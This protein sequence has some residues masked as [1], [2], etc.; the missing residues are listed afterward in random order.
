MA[1]ISC[2]LVSFSPFFVKPNENNCME[3]LNVTNDI[4]GLLLLSQP[5]SELAFAFPLL[6]SMC[7][8]FW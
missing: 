8:L 6:T 3:K 2:I 5:K 1:R 7:G 4:S